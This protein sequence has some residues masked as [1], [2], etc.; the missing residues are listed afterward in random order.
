M[1]LNVIDVSAVRT[2][3]I[4]NTAVKVFVAFVGRFTGSFLVTRVR[5][6]TWLK[7]CGNKEAYIYYGS[8]CR[9]YRNLQLCKHFNR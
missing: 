2:A 4:M 8:L 9:G 3:G 7:W 6:V 5:S 1:T